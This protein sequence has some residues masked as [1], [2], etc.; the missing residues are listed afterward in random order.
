MAKINIV[1]PMAGRGQRFKNAGYTKNKPFID[2]LGVPMIQK[3]ICNILP[4]QHEINK[5]IF[6][7]QKEDVDELNRVIE[8]LLSRPNFPK[9]TCKVIPIDYITS[10]PASTIMLA[11]S[12]ID[13]DQGL[14]IANSDQYINNFDVD[15]FLTLS[16]NY[17]GGIVCFCH[18]DPKW[19]YVRIKNGLIVE[20]AE[21]NPISDHATCGIYYF[22]Y[23]QDFVTGY[24][25]MFLNNDRANN[26]FYVAPI[27]NYRATYL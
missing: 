11:E 5:I 10:G 13:N 1:I 23:G 12:Y 19:S 4:K 25:L 14:L 22:K 17:D 2:V 21:K 26:E 8:N 18:D 16:N 24:D 7:C 9:F 27:Y 6:I 20:T 15:N 3:I